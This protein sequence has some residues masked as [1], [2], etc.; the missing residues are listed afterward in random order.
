MVKIALK[1]KLDGI[2]CSPKEIKIVKKISKGNLIIITPGIRFIDNK[3]KV[4]LEW[5]FRIL[6]SFWYACSEWGK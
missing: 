6:E 2:V 1:T 3:I 5:E 4:V